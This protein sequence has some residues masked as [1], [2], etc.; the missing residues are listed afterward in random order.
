MDNRDSSD[1]NVATLALGVTTWVLALRL[2]ADVFRDSG[3]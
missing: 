3:H 1:L 2:R